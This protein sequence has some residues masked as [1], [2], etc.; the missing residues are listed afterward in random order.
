MPSYIAENHL[1]CDVSAVPGLMQ[2]GLLEVHRTPT[3]LRATQESVEAFKRDCVS[4]ASIARSIG[5]ASSR[6]LMRL[7]EGNRTKL[8]LV[9][10]TGRG[11]QRLFIQVSDQHKLMEARLN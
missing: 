2:M 1:L 9:P 10:E 3:G 4:L 8:S 11:S 5:T 7:C 6:G